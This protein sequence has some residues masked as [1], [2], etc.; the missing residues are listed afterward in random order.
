MKLL[1]A[2]KKVK[3]K[4]FHSVKVDFMSKVKPGH[5]EEVFCNTQTNTCK[6]QAD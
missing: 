1:C 2:M 6:I 5:I 4:F 3:S